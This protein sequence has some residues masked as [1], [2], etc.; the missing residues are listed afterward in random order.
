MMYHASA[1][2]A[3][4]LFAAAASASP[5]VNVVSADRD[6]IVRSVQVTVSGGPRAVEARLRW[7]AR[8]VCRTLDDDRLTRD[9][10]HCYHAALANA[11]AQVA[12][13]SQFAAAGAA[14]QPQSL[15]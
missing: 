5:Q 4:C 6:T 3:L 7:A 10:L 1:C 2:A 12:T 13:Q 8:Q 9:S 15:R 11:R 14:Q